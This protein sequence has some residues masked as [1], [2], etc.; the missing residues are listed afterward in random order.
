ME[1]RNLNLTVRSIRSQTTPEHEA[2]LQPIY[3]T[4]IAKSHIN[5][6]Y[7]VIKKLT[8]KNLCFNQSI[9]MY[10]LGTRLLH[11]LGS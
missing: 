1:R 3:I 2:N 8:D 10:L 4:C 5:I 11:D 6:L 7:S 9:D